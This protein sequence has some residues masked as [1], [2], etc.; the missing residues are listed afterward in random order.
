MAKFAYHYLQVEQC[1]SLTFSQVDQWDN[2]KG[3][4]TS[5]IGTA[6]YPAASLFNH[7]CAANTARINIGT[8]VVLVATRN[9]AKMQEVSVS[10]SVTFQECS[11]ADRQSYLSRR[12]RFTCRCPAC[13]GNWETQGGKSQI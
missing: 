11:Y 8:K 2:A 5:A 7:S 3:A 13:L 10:Y 4:R 9:I 1:N 6:I 12:Y